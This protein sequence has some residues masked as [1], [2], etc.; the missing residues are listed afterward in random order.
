M[1]RFLQD[2]PGL[3][4]LQYFILVS[5]F[6]TSSHLQKCPSLDDSCYMHPN[7]CSYLLDRNLRE[8]HMPKRRLPSYKENLLSQIDAIDLG[9]L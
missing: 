7:F 8:S 5:C 4:L 1:P 9:S 3:C 6:D 2:N